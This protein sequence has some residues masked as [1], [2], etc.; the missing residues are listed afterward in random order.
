MF[1]FSQWLLRIMRLSPYQKQIDSQAKALREAIDK[2]DST[3]YPA[4]MRREL[5]LPLDAELIT[6]T[7]AEYNMAVEA[8]KAHYKQQN[9]DVQVS[10]W[11]LGHFQ[12]ELEA[13]QWPYENGLDTP[14]QLTALKVMKNWA[15]AFKAKDKPNSQELLRDACDPTLAVNDAKKT[16]LPPPLSNLEPNSPWINSLPDWKFGSRR[17]GMEPRPHVNLEKPE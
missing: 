17:P 2:A 7:V 6:V 8:A 15:G 12:K 10:S 1:K 14:W 3:W 5:E 11:L 16:V 4:A 13:G 9:L